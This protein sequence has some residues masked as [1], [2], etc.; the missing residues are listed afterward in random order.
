MEWVIVAKK[1]N[2]KFLQEKLENSNV[3]ITT[4]DWADD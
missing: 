3:S 2:D 4:K 1:Q